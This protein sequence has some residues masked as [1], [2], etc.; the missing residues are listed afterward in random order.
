MGTGGGEKPSSGARRSSTGAKPGDNAA[1]KEQK[2]SPFIISDDDTA[3]TEAETSDEESLGEEEEQED[4]GEPVTVE[5]SANPPQHWGLEPPRVGDGQLRRGNKAKRIRFQEH[6]ENPT[7]WSTHVG[8]FM[9]PPK[10]TA[11]DEWRGS[12]CPKNLALEHPAAEKMLEYAMGG[13]SS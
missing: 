3:T 8:E 9:V 1:A 5:W 2:I 4:E 6:Q 7:Y 10:Q 11:K 13:L 12:M